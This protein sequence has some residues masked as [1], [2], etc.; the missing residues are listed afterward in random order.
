MS[1]YLAGGI[2]GYIMVNLSAAPQTKMFTLKQRTIVVYWMGAIAVFIFSLFA[3]YLKDVPSILFAVAFS[4]GR[5]LLALFWGSVLV[6]CHIGY[7]GWLERAFGHRIL[8][9]LN[10]LSYMMYMVNPVVISWLSLGRAETSEHFDIFSY[11]RF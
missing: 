4:M 11:V 8:L 2:A 6:M 5:F 9:H 1:P 10:K 7:G 3:T